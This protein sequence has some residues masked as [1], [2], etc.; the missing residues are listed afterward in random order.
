MNKGKQLW[1]MFVLMLAVITSFTVGFE[2]VLSSLDNST[3]YK[4][5]SL[6]SD[7]FFLIDIIVQF[8]T[9]YFSV[10]GEEVRDWKKIAIRYL[11][12]MF[13]IDLVATIPWSWI[14]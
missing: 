6:V 3:S 9:T 5:F 7:F 11:K 4:V 8:R 1:D 13:I 12:G 14:N 10:E 2:L